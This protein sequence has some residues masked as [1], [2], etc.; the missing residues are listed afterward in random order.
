MITDGPYGETK[1][2]LGGIL[3]LEATSLDHA[4]QRMSQHLGGK[5]RPCEIRPVTDLN[6]MIQ[7]SDQRRSRATG[8]KA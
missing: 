4:I 7:E 5:A 6:D 3:L 8:K 1:E 2:Y